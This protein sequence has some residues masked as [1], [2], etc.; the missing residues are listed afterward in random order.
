MT[1]TQTTAA[2]PAEFGTWT[3]GPAEFEAT[4]AKI[5]KIND[6]ARR[7]GFTGRFELTGVE[8]TRSYEVNGFPV[9]EVIIKAT[10][11]GEA[12]RYDG[13]RLLATLDWDEAAGLIVRTAPGVESVN[14]EGL[15]EGYCAHCGSKRHRKATYLVGH[16]D[17]RQVQVGSTCIKDF[18]GW[19]SPVVF[20][21]LDELGEEMDRAIGGGYSPVFTTETVL[22][23]AWAVVKTFGYVKADD[24]SRTPTK[25]VVC[26]VLDPRDQG[27]RALAEKMAPVVAESAE[28]GRK[29]RAFLLSDE[30]NGTGE[31]VLN[32]KAYAAADAATARSIGFLASAP[33]AWARAQEQSLIRQREVGDV[34][35]EWV[36]TIGERIDVKVRIKAVAWGEDIG[37]GASAI[38][39]MT[40]EKGRLFKWFSSR[41]ALGEEPSKEF[42]TLRGTVTRHS[43]WRGAKETV[44]NRCKVIK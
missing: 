26:E 35:S 43:E 7:R 34:V 36:G 29:I 39:T 14:R 1:E 4:A 6:R 25:Q 40:D 33:Q 15:T 23:L 5:A 22:A 31:Y 41:A 2:A 21:T 10:I 19:S 30:F 12:P 9:E 8:E 42:I 24:W 44:I 32:M 16:S 17:G 13:W 11:T 38:Y 28:M 27:G 20:I 37:Y 18:L 3:L